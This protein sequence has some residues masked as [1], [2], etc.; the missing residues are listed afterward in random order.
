MTSTNP[1]DFAQRLILIRRHLRGIEVA[2]D[3]LEHDVNQRRGEP[4]PD[5]ERA[6]Q[7][8]REVVYQAGPG[9]VKVIHD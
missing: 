4:Q 7:R 1:D 5:G 6:A 2:L 3:A 8:A 9:E